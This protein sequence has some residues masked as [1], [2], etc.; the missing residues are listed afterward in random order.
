MTGELIC[1]DV[2]S[3]TGQNIDFFDWKAFERITE[4]F[5]LICER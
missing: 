1:F 4:N 2:F 3:K 5:N